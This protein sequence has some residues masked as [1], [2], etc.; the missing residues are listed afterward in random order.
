MAAPGFVSSDTWWHL[1]AGRW[2]WEHRAV[3]RTDP[4]SWSVPGAPWTDHEWLF[5]AMLWPASLAGPAGVVLF[6][7]VPVLAAFFFLWRLARPAGVLAPA[8][9]AAGALGTCPALTARPQLF[10]LA[11]L[12]FLLWAFGG[13]GRRPWLL[14][15]VPPAVALWANLH[16]AAVLGPALAFLAAA[17]A[18]LPPFRAGRLAHEPDAR[19]E[20]LLAAALSALAAAASPLG[21]GIYGYAWKAASDPFFAA[22]IQEWKPPPFGDPLVRGLILPLAGLVLLGFLAGRGRV[23]PLALLVA[24]GLA[25]QALAAY[26][27]LSLAAVAGTALAGELLS[28]ERPEGRRLGRAAALGVAAGLLAA[29][30]SAGPPRTFEEAAARCGYPVEVAAEIRPGERVLNPYDWGGYLVWRGVPVFVDGRADLY[31]W[32]RDV[33]RDAMEMPARLE[34][35]KLAAKYSAGAVLCRAGSHADRWLARSPGWAEA[36]RRGGAVLYRRAAGG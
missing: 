24:C 4:F 10:D 8:V 29:F 15:A 33:L 32:G 26:R 28:E 19:R 25:V 14:W 34:F 7:A 30:L 1:A 23:R 2:I 12:G 16:A 21:F 13:A 22:W 31:G 6:C 3:P 18:W 35:E 9:F 27:H 5:Q 20:L 17:L 11:F 36:A